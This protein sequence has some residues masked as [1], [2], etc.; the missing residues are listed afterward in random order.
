MNYVPLN[1]KPSPSSIS[2]SL[3]Y[4]NQQK[5]NLHL[6]RPHFNFTM[7]GHHTNSPMNIPDY[8]KYVLANPI[9]NPI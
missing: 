9:I 6:P 5:P 1:R 3:S 4:I 2:N 7:N 8:H